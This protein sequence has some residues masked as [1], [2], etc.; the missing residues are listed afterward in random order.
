VGATIGEKD[1]RKSYM[2]MA[3]ATDAVSGFAFQPELGLPEDSTGRLLVRALV[4]A[5]REWKCIPTE[6]RVKRKDIKIL[7]GPLSERLG[8][9]VRVTKSLPMLKSMLDHFLAT[10]GAPGEY[11]SF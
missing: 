4:G 2:R 3:L 8:F 9:E 7:L 10:I 6:V 11:S 5:M 1:E